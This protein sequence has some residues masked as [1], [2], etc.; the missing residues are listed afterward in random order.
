M[1]SLPLAQARV[2]ASLVVCRLVSVDSAIET[3]KSLLSLTNTRSILTLQSSRFA[4]C[5]YVD[6]DIR[7]C[8]EK[9]YRERGSRH[10]RAHGCVE[11]AQPLWNNVCAH[12]DGGRR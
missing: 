4:K 12:G 2:M 8:R 6:D 11:A 9:R 10:R 3:S 1:D 5:H 7:H